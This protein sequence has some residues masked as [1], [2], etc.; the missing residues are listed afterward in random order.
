MKNRQTISVLQ[1]KP[2]KSNNGLSDVFWSHIRLDEMNL[3]GYHVVVP[4]LY[5]ESYKRKNPAYAGFKR[6]RD[7]T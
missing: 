1:K 2:S 5:P 7:G 6:T 4:M 3:L